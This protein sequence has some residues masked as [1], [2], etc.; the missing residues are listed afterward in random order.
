ME[1]TTVK[2]INCTEI[3]LKGILSK[4][5][6]K[7]GDSDTTSTAVLENLPTEYDNTTSSSSNSGPINRL[8]NRKVWR[9][10]RAY[11]ISVEAAFKRL[12]K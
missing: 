2:P 12:Y 4:I 6:Q 3:E 10:A 1:D 11:K 9:Y 5:K 8:Y 7:F